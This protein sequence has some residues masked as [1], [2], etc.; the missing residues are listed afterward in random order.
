MLVP[1]TSIQTAGTAAGTTFGVAKAARVYD[2]K[3]L[4]SNGDGTFSDAIAGF[5]AI[6][7]YKNANPSQK[8]V[9]N[10]SFGGGYNFAMNQAARELVASLNAWASLHCCVLSRK[11]N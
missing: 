5:D 2:V 8:V 3:I 9:V 1:I 11:L 10:G 6:A 7:D 4:G